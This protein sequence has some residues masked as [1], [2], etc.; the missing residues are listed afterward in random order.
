[1]HEDTHDGYKRVQPTDI[2]FSGVKL[3][4]ESMAEGIDFCGLVK[5]INKGFFS[6]Y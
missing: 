4:N 3:A 2:W 1:M 5:M 6:L